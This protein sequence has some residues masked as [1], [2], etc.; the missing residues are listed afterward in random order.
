MSNNGNLIEALANSRM[1]HEYERAFSE[2]TGMPVTL[3]STANWQLP[4]HGKRKE[5]PFCA[6]VASKSRT[7]AGCLQMQER[8][9]LKAARK[10]ATLT[11]SFGLC[12]AAVPVRLGNETVGFLQTGHVMRQK[13]TARQFNDV[14]Q[15][16]KEHG[17]DVDRK[18]VR[19]AYFQTPVVSRKKLDSL[20]H[21]LSV[22]ADHLSMKGCQIA[23]Q[24]AHAEPPVISKARQYIEKHHSEELSLG[25]VASAVHTSASYFCRLFK[26][27]TGFNY[28]EFLSCVRI[29]KAKN[30]LLNPNLRVSEIA[31]D[32]GFQSLTHF[33][34]VFKRIVGWSP[35]EYRTKLP[36]P[37]QPAGKDVNLARRAFSLL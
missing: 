12:E 6:L 17:L 24:Q 15:Q 32:A 2:A 14:A 34:R 37:V 18:K 16:L 25:Q 20:T 21:L 19:E 11:C 36:G 26:R 9:R 31:Y 35:T 27:A 10:A 22:F 8:L 1:C 28:T 30:L 29:E 5:N 13:P 33:N 4:F 23:L 7:C 3:R